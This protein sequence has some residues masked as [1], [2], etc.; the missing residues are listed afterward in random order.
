MT[1]GNTYDTPPG[2]ISTAEAAKRLKLTQRRIRQLLNDGELQ[3]IKV[4]K[5]LWLV[6]ETSV[7]QFRTEK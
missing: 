6:S 2:Y 1:D 4:S 7:E 5:N 3:G